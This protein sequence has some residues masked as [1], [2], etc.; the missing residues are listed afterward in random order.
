[1]SSV[2]EGFQIVT[3][4]PADHQTPCEVKANLRFHWTWCQVKMGSIN[5]KTVAV[6]KMTPIKERFKIYNYIWPLVC[7]LEALTR[8]LY[9]IGVSFCA[10][11]FKLVFQRWYRKC[12]PTNMR[13]QTKFFSSHNIIN[14]IWKIN[15]LSNHTTFNSHVFLVTFSRKRKCF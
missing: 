1:M 13:T 2:V 9:F 8:K 3:D 11:V 12:E 4:R 14:I 15:C 6:V 7:T 5:F 10:M